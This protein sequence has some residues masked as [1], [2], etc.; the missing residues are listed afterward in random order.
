[1]LMARADPYECLA[2]RSA[3]CEQN[4]LGRRR[5]CGIPMTRTERS[6][7]SAVSNDIYKMKG[8]DGLSVAVM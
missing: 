2:D 4:N 8:N 1:V 3:C 7:S 6:K 5:V